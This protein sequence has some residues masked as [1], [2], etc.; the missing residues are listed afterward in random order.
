MSENTSSTKPSREELKQQLRDEARCTL[1]RSEFTQCE[2]II[3]N[4]VVGGASVGAAWAAV[5]AQGSPLSMLGLPAV[6]AAGSVGMLTYPMHTMPLKLA[7]VFGFD[8]KKIDAAKYYKEAY[9]AVSHSKALE[10]VPVARE[11]LQAAGQAACTEI[12]GW[13][14]AIQFARLCQQAPQPDAPAAPQ[15]EKTVPEISMDELSACAEKFLSGQKDPDA[16]KAEYDALCCA[17]AQAAS[18]LSP[19]LRAQYVKLCDLGV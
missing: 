6:V 5:A 1:T 17:F 18:Q 15:P 11:I 9:E 7:E 4:A 13:Q 3:H 19:A 16:D 8:L 14:L 10:D 12:V 2:K